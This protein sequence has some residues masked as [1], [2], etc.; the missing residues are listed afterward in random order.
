[1]RHKLEHE[2]GKPSDMF[3]RDVEWME[4]TAFACDARPGA[5]L[6]VVSGRRRQGKTFLLRALSQATGGFYFAADEA[7]DGDSLHQLGA[8][9]G[10]YLNLPS[11]LRFGDWHEA[12]DALLA[13]GSER[14]VLVVIDEFPYLAKAN[15]AL[16]SILQNAIAPLRPE[17]ERSRSRMLLCGSAMTFMGTLLS[18]NAPL[19]GRAG[20]ELVVP[21]L[22]YQLAAQFWNIT[23]PALAI[24]VHAIVGGTPA[25]RREFARDDTPDNADDFDS[26]V[27]RTVLNPA[28]P[29]FREAR[30]LLAA[31]AELRDQGL[32]QSVLAA[33]AD[34]NTVRG[35]IAK[36]IGRK[37]GDLAHPLNV[38]MDCGLVYRRPDAFRENQT[39]YEIAEPLITFYHAVMRPIWSDLAHTRDPARLWERSQPRFT[40]N[41]LGG[42]FEQVARHWT[43]YFAPEGVVGGFPSRVEPG[44][45]NDPASKKTRQVDVVA[46]GPGHDD[47]ETML[48]IGEV[49]WHETMG[50]PHLERLRHIRGLLTAQGR[51]GAARARLLCF[52]GAGFTAELAKEASGASDVQLLTPADLYTG[53]L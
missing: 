44:T 34:G 6:G 26:W 52:S 37:S 19:R 53:V 15:P 22:D 28:S 32:Y 13:L 41:V 12:I 38:L 49:K 50:M 8:A 20:L 14:P 39:T 30:Y 48:A 21:T 47:R 33:I 2:L 23:D 5:T 35:N 11:G 25:Y 9:V 31:E 1:M 7:T 51:R 46:L 42:H 17:R 45:L 3:D 18:G 29:L 16:P 24:K 43:R 10:A 4:L 27:K 36:Y 40:S